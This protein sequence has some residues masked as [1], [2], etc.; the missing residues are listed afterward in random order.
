MTHVTILGMV[1]GV[2]T[3][4]SF[5][6]Q[7]FKVWRSKSASDLSFFMLLILNTGMLLWLVYGILIEDIAVIM[8]H[9]VSLILASLILGFKVKYQYEQRRQA[10]RL[11]AL[12]LEVEQT[13]K[14]AYREQSP[15][16]ARPGQTL[17]PL[18]PIAG[19]AI[20]GTPPTGQD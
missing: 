1:A 17:K 16:A 4:V 18:P 5:L 2:M 7:L 14:P 13:E 19:A 12:R 15:G 11:Q 20:A 6:P 9:S 3:T 8:T 10:R